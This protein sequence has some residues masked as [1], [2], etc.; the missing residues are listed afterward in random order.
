MMAYAQ[1]LMV[2]RKALKAAQKVNDVALCQEILQEAHRTDVRSLV[3]QAR[4]MAGGAIDPIGLFRSVK[5]REKLIE[6]RGLKS[7]ATGL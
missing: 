1:A 5:V 2:D 3:A 6:E 7:V 4:L